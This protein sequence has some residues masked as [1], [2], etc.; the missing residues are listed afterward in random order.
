[1]V[2]KYSSTTTGTSKLILPFDKSPWFWRNDITLL[3]LDRYDLHFTVVQS[4]DLAN[5]YINYCV[6]ITWYH[7]IYINLN[8]YILIITYFLNMFN[9]HAENRASF[10]LPLNTSV[11]Y[12]YKMSTPP[13]CQVQTP[14]IMSNPRDI[15]IDV[16]V[17]ICSFRWHANIRQDYP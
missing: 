6:I 11:N 5:I 8:I 10:F 7:M 17:H 16:L 12:F 2:L 14:D 4:R 13:S 9:S 1:M 3:A 15:H